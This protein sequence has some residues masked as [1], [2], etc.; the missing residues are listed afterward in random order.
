[1]GQAWHAGSNFSSRAEEA[2]SF[3]MASLQGRPA[4]QLQEAARVMEV[5][6]INLASRASSALSIV[7]GSP[8][9]WRTIVIACHFFT[10]D[11]LRSAL[12]FAFPLRPALRAPAARHATRARI[13]LNA[14]GQS[15]FPCQ[16][17]LWGHSARYPTA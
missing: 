12:Y 16:L 13:N 11:S 8:G 17:P 6:Y 15:P 1:M 4:R 2:C 7:F 14:T 3:L 10:G 9:G 5:P